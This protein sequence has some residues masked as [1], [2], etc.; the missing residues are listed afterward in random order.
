M[1]FNAFL[2]ELILNINGFK[3]KEL[4]YQCVITGWVKWINVTCIVFPA[5]STLTV[6]GTKV[7]MPQKNTNQKLSDVLPE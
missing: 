3:S 6:R 5:S 1:H 2:F 4:E 7:A